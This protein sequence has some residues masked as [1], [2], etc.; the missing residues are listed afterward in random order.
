LLSRS[1][2]S[3][4]PVR[5]CRTSRPAVHREN[6]APHLASAPAACSLGPGCRLRERRSRRLGVAGSPRGHTSRFGCSVAGATASRRVCSEGRQRHR[7]NRH[8]HCE[9]RRA[10]VTATSPPSARM[11]T[12]MLASF[13][14]R[15]PSRVSKNGILRP[16]S[17][18]PRFA[19]QRLRMTANLMTGRNLSE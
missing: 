5:L 2:S 11:P 8:G 10:G 19:L 3:L 13:V 6:E 9:Q 18:V 17:G 15:R 16:S 12:R 4:P 7:R 1:C 14:H